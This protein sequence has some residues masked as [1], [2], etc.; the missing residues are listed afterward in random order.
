MST[1]RLYGR[2]APPRLFHAGSIGAG[3]DEIKDTRVFNQNR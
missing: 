1:R 2:L 3:H